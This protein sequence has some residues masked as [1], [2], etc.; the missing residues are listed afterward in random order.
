MLDES[1]FYQDL[2]WAGKERR[3][4]VPQ[5][6]KVEVQKA[7]V[8]GEPWIFTAYYWWQGRSHRVET[9]VFV[10]QDEKAAMATAL[11]KDFSKRYPED[12]ARAFDWR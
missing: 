10:G 2:W 8:P 12:A 5:I 1:V 3:K 6:V 11:T 9:P 4:T 7:L